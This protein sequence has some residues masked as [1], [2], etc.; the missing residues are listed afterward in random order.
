[1]SRAIDIEINGEFIDVPNS[2]RFEMENPMFKTELYQGDWSFPGEMPMTPKNSRILGFA[3]KIGIANRVLTYDCVVYFFG[4]PRTKAK[5]IIKRA[6]DNSI[7]FSLVAGLKALKYADTKISDL[8]LGE[9]DLGNTQDEV[10][11]TAKLASKEGDWSVYGFTFVPFYAPNFFNGLNNNF[12]GVVNMQNSTNG[13]FYGNSLT[14]VNNIHTQVPWLFLFWIMNKIFEHE[15]LVPS[16]NFWT[17]TELQT[18]LITNNRSIELRPE[19]FNTRVIGNVVQTLTSPLQTVEF[20]LGPGGTYDNIFA[21]DDGLNQYVLKKTGVL[22]LKI[23]LIW[24]PV[25]PPAYLTNNQSGDPGQFVLYFDGSPV[26]TFPLPNS[27]EGDPYR[28][29][30]LSYKMTVAPGDIGKTFELVYNPTGWTGFGSPS[31]PYVELDGNSDFLAMYDD[32][33]VPAKAGQ[34]ITFK[35]HVPDWTCAKLLA[36]VKKLGV[37]F[38]FSTPGEVVMKTFDQILNTS[39]AINI[40]KLASPKYETDYEAVGKGVRIGYNFPAD[41]LQGATEEDSKITFDA[42]KLIGE[43]DNERELP[44]P[45]V[46][47][48]FVVTRDASQLFVV[49]KDGA[50]LNSWKQIGFYY[51]D[52]VIGLGDSDLTLELAPIQM[53]NQNNQGGSSDENLALMPYFPGI[54]SSNLYG[55]GINPYQPRILFWRG[56]NQTGNT[57]SPKGGLYVYAGTSEFGINKNQLGRFNFRLDKAASVVRFT[58]EHLYNLINENGV[59]EK[60]VKVDTLLLNNIKNTSKIECDYDVFLVKSISVVGVKSGATIKAYLLKL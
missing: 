44:E 36:E 52:F 26:V 59:T 53:C 16:G 60:D 15:G 27:F 10:L 32:T 50:N 25:F 38:D 33:S 55:L 56:V 4:D 21:W 46:E 54:G 1:L 22:L 45:A 24:K 9:Y 8:V 11:A 39:S 42:E 6:T 13:D 31:L 58:S 37:N 23:V 40:S 5:F 2:I 30:P 3:N 18:L 29:Y 19:G 43:V 48:T 47:G 12:Q 20:A 34:F 41:P 17:N 51:P 28:A 7:S 14:A 57:Q 49:Q 35:D